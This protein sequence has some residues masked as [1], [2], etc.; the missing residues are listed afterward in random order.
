[1]N[2]WC[3]IRPR[4][5]FQLELCHRL[6]RTR[7]VR[8]R[9]SSV[10]PGTRHRIRLGLMNCSCRLSVVREAAPTRDDFPPHESKKQ[11]PQLASRQ[12]PVDKREQDC[13]ASSSSDEVEVRPND[14]LDAAVT[15]AGLSLPLTHLL[16]SLTRKRSRP[17]SNEGRTRNNRSPHQQGSSPRSRSRKNLP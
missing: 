17:Q 16:N 11:R 10:V 4:H 13:D 9:R 15:V 2:C 12:S 3:L 7:L 6:V 5:M 1:M 8:T 14:H